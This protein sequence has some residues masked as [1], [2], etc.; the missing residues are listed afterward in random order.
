MVGAFY[1]S[2][3]GEV[4][5][6]GDPAFRA[7]GKGRGCYKPG[8]NAKFPAVDAEPAVFHGFFF[9]WKALNHPFCC[10]QDPVLIF[11]HKKLDLL[12]LIFI[13]LGYNTRE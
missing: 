9:I 2:H 12:V 4:D 8:S 10:R 5:S 11:G 1:C 13:L 3:F 7:V 6:F